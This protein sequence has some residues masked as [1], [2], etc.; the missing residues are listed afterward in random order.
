MANWHFGDTYWDW[1]LG[2][3]DWHFGDTYW[4]WLLGVFVDNRSCRRPRIVH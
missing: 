1:L 4:D 2:V 3:A